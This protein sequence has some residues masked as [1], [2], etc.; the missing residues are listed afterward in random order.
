MVLLDGGCTLVVAET[1]AARLTAFDVAPDGGL[2]GRRVWAALD[3]KV[4]PDGICIDAE[5]AIWVA[6]PSTSECLR[7]HQGGEVAQRIATRRRAFACALGGAN[8][9]SLYICTAKSHD[10]DR[11]RRERNG[12]IEAFSVSVA[13]PA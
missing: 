10:P 2:S 9:R 5:D 11:Q 1:W 6:S 12:R 13:A 8:G 4:Y 3:R 7:V